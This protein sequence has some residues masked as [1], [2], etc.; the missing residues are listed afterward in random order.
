MTYEQRHGG[1][2]GGNGYGDDGDDGDGDGD[3]DGGGDDDDGDDDGDGDGGG[4]DDDGD[5]GDGGDDDDGDDDDDDGRF[6]LVLEDPG[7]SECRARNKAPYRLYFPSPDNA[8]FSVD[9]DPDRPL[10]P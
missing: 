5:D 8:M 4:D 6:S 9:L 7:V 2:D 10:E 3:G 1:D